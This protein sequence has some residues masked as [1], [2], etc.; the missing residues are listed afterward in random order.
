MKTP[1][2]IRSPEERKRHLEYR[3][4]WLSRMIN[5]TRYNVRRAEKELAAA[6]KEVTGGSRHLAD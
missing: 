5:V 4:D 3:R 2:V 1:T 6:Q